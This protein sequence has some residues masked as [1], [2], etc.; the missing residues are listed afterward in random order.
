VAFVG[1]RVSGWVIGRVGAARTLLFGELFDNAANFVA[2]VKPTVFSP[3]LLGSPAYGMST[4]AQQT[5]LQR[6]FTDRERATMGSLASLLGSVLYALVALGAG[7]V[8]D[9]WGIVAALLAIQAV[10]LI[11]LPLAWWVHSHASSLPAGTGTV[12]G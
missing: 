2:L 6:E 4:I 1:F 5:L 11:A 8:A 12:T 3:V 10:V 9:R 7:L